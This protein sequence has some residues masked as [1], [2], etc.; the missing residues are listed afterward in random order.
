M[1][2]SDFV[3]VACEC[4]SRLRKRS[5]VIMVTNLR[6]EDDLELDTALKLLSQAH[7]VLLTSLRERVL[8]DTVNG[9][10]DTFTDALRVS[11]AHAYLKRRHETHRRLSTRGI[12]SL[13]ALPE[14]L[15]IA[16]INRYLEIKSKGLL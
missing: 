1:Q 11:A 14:Q 4:Q 16:M 9:P 3:N 13:D 2:T 10:I 6:D 12:H 5:L 15:P 8:E 7:L